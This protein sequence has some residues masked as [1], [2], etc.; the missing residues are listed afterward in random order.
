MVL[1]AVLLAACP[2]SRSES[3]AARST[4]PPVLTET[5]ATAAPGVGG[6][7][8]PTIRP[9]ETLALGATHS[10]L[11]TAAGA[12]WCWGSHRFQQLG[13]QES[14][15]YGASHP[16]P[17]VVPGLDTTA[18]LVAG[19]FHTCAISIHGILRCWGHGGFGQLGRGDRVDG[20]EPR[21]VELEG[22]ARVVVA[23]EAHS[24][25]LDEEGGVSCFGDNTFGQLGDSTTNSRL[26]PHRLE[27]RATDLTAGR[28]HTCAVADLETGASVRCWGA[29]FAG[30]LGPIPRPDGYR[31]FPIE[32]QIAE[33]ALVQR[34][35]SGSH[36][37]CAVNDDP[38]S[39][40]DVAHCWGHNGFGQLGP[41]RSLRFEPTLLATE[42]FDALAAGGG[43]QCTLTDGAVSCWGANARGQLGDGSDTSRRRPTPP[44]GL[45]TART[46][47]A[48]A[49]H[50]CAVT[51]DG[52]VWCWGSSADGQTG[53]SEQTKLRAPEPVPGISL[54]SP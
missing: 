15:G 43:H 48:G 12:V 20:A 18:R 10:C 2:S 14:S 17:R 31:S 9:I 23:G 24:C 40:R 21:V 54:D 22:R 32:I 3:N 27:L 8:Q 42:P 39:S 41:G 1:P 38:S 5:E 51:T 47:A 34:L 46:I 50:S 16:E 28:H 6:R 44:S 7:S 33:P 45:P 49:R 53:Q 19:S 30:Q 11:L 4:E 26:R 35:T 36:H 52:R 25:V 29:G 13:H 37:T